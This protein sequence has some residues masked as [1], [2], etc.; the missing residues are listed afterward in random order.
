MILSIHYLLMCN[1]KYLDPLQFFITPPPS[2]G[3]TPLKI[4][5]PKSLNHN[6]PKLAIQINCQ[7]AL[8][9][10]LHISSS[11]ITIYYFFLQLKKENAQVA[12]ILEFVVTPSTIG[13][14]KV[15]LGTFYCNNVGDL[16]LI[17]TNIDA[18]YPIQRRRDR[19]LTFFSTILYSSRVNTPF[20]TNL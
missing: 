17:F 8:T 3:T 19:Y 18:R 1:E 6:I 4:I 11:N 14:N 13:K 20:S 9:D 7:P 10:L 15:R 2:T 16:P 5:L 12:K